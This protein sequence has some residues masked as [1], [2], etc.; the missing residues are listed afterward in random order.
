MD[1]ILRELERRWQV[2]GSTEDEASYLGAKVR[3]GEL[4]RDR[5]EL[6][7]YLG[8]KASALALSPE[9]AT[10]TQALRTAWRGGPVLLLSAAR[11]LP[12]RFSGHSMRVQRVLAA[13]KVGC[14]L[15]REHVAKAAFI[16]QLQDHRIERP[17]YE[18]LSAV[19]LLIDSCFGSDV[20]KTAA[21]RLE[22]LKVAADLNPQ[23]VADLL[24]R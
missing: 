21:L 8:S 12:V 9:V 1:A 6:A 22:F 16:K 14:E 2:S 15:G 19:S 13:I 20:V 3:C 4:G 18:L 24:L 5:L 17:P 23:I 7:A 11:T 10:H